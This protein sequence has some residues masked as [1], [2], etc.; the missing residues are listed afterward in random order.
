M[1]IDLTQI[2]KD[3]IEFDELITVDL[4]DET[5]QLIE[6][7]RISGEL[8]KGIVQID[9]SGE[10]NGKVKIDCSRCI[11]PVETIINVPFKASYITEEHYTKEKESELQGEDFEIAIY[12]GEKIDLS[13]LATEQILLNLPTQVFC[14]ENCQGLCPKCGQNLNK[15]K[16]SCETKE[17]DPRWAALKQMKD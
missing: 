2:S 12:D 11:T 7:C 4:E 10:V 13:Q 17:I 14:Q 15:E 9:L 8:K 6:P 1:Y 5:A 16:C 3:V